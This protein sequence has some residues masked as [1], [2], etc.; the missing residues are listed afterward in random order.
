VK[1]SKICLS[2][3]DKSQVLG[4]KFEF[5]HLVFNFGELV[6]FVARSVLS[7]E[8]LVIPA[9][10]NPPSANLEIVSIQEQDCTLLPSNIDQPYG[11]S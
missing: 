5:L 11:E 7:L 3:L 9:N 1:T 10:L 8:E 6:S 2:F 4:Q